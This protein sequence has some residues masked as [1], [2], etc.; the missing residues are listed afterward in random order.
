ME[1][2]AAVLK[3]AGHQFADRE[4]GGLNFDPK[5]RFRFDHARHG[6]R[7]TA[8]SQSNTA[9][10]PAQGIAREH[11]TGFQVNLL[12]APGNSGGSN[13]LPSDR[14]GIRCLAARSDVVILRD[15]N[16]GGG[17]RYGW[18][19]ALFV[20]LARGRRR[21]T[22]HLLSQV[23]RLSGLIAIVV[24][25]KLDPALVDATPGVHFID[26]MGPMAAT[27]MSPF[28]DRAGTV[29]AAAVKPQQ[30]QAMQRFGRVRWAIGTY[31][32]KVYTEM[33]TIGLT[34]TR[35]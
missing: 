30:A 27:M 21:R 5:R 32:K 7:D 28:A 11:L 19:L 16:F 2:A 12:S 8:P 6:C 23:A 4:L 26:V 15:A 24:N 3:K 33:M 34:G 31:L 18:N 20:D 13:F 1:A 9:I 10:L 35:S 22:R 29:Q 17:A 14:K 25:G